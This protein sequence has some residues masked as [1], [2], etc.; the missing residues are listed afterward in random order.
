MLDSFLASLRRRSDVIGWT[1]R[2]DRI[3]GSQL[4]YSGGR[5][6]AER[7]VREERFRLSVVC[8]T[9][10]PDGS[11]GCGTGEA[12]LLPNEPIP[13]AIERAIEMARHVHNPLHGLPAPAPLPDVLLEEPDLIQRP[14]ERL[15]EAHAQLTSLAGKHPNLRLTAAEWHSEA[16]ESRL[17]NSRG[18]E[19][20]QRGTTFGLE[21]VL[22]T[23][24]GDERVEG[25]HERSRRRSADVPLEEEFETLVQRTL[26]R[27]KAASAPEWEGPVVVRD[28]TLASFVGGGPLR[29]L[30]TA[31]NH[32]AKRSRWEIGQ[33]V[34]PD[35]A[36][37]EPLTVW[38]NRVLPFG[39]YSCRFDSEGI[40]GQRL[41]LIQDNVLRAFSA[42]QR[43]AEYLDLPP[44][45]D[46][47]N[48]ELPAGPSPAAQ[49]LSPPYLEVADFS[50]FNPDPV[51][52]DFATEIRLGYQVEDGSRKPFRGGLLIGNLLAALGRARWSR[53]T[54]FF[55][56]Y[57][58]PTTG[59]FEGLKVAGPTAG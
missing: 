51:T 31:S 53:E 41:L 16:T 18:Q 39:T 21:W 48:I 23:G 44:T 9:S 5:T 47:G 42:S 22:V 6:E 50:W 32:Y 57:Q 33:R 59:R 13:P 34:V 28:A 37:G 40:P 24:E 58:G 19:G 55:G 52:G 4:F 45:G 29:F 20:S 49:L 46:F 30:G 14:A 1:V 25:F 10:G 54:G 27:R 12:T 26:D 3:Q 38:A 56:E 2:Q 8:P 43:Y 7:Q 36:D 35:G 17:V 11:K 15:R